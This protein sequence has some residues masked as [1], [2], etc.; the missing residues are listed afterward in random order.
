MSHPRRRPRP[1]RARRTG[2][3]GRCP[4]TRTTSDDLLDGFRGIAATLR[5][6]GRIAGAE[7]PAAPRTP[8]TCSATDGSADDL[9]ATLPDDTWP[10]L[11]VSE[12]AGNG[13]GNLVDDDTLA[14]SDF[15]DWIPSDA[16]DA[17]RAQ[18][19]MAVGPRIDPDAD[20]ERGRTGVPVG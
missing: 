1:G 18:R 19:R 13:F 20:G 15:T 10:P 12:L 5:S 3:P 7:R 11:S 6:P 14:D 17:D 9:V 2:Q 16:E 4:T 8:P